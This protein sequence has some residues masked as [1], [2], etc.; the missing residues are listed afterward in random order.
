M[1]R[2]TEGRSRLSAGILFRRSNAKQ[3]H[4]RRGR[5]PLPTGRRSR[6]SKPRSGFDKRCALSA[7]P[8]LYFRRFVVERIRLTVPGTHT[9]SNVPA[10]EIIMSQVS[11]TGSFSPDEPVCGMVMVAPTTLALAA[12]STKDV[13]ADDNI[14]FL[15]FM[16]EVF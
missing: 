10:P 11:V 6:Q 13:S 2:T 7:G 1:R 12:S 15:D 14:E 16:L 8:G 3:D 9:I 5:R 4:S